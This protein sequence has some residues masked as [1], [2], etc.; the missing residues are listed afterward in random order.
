MR[1]HY[2]YVYVARPKEIDERCPVGGVVVSCEKGAMGSQV[3]MT[4][5]DVADQRFPRKP[6]EMLAL[7]EVH[8]RIEKLQVRMMFLDRDEQQAKFEKF[9]NAVV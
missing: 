8:R 2:Y 6:W 1:K 5:Y 9:M 7:R 4:A 3:A